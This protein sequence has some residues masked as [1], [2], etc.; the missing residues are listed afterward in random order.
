[1]QRSHRLSP[2]PR[3]KGS[4]CRRGMHELLGLVYLSTRGADVQGEAGLCTQPYFPFQ[5][6]CCFFSWVFLVRRFCKFN[7]RFKNSSSLFLYAYHYI[8]S[9]F[10]IILR[11]VASLSWLCGCACV[12]TSNAS[13]LGWCL[14]R[15]MLRPYSVSVP[16]PRWVTQ[17]WAGLPCPY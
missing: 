9:M 12:C 17:C 3:G 8:L 7:Y 16:R 11:P 1:M 4:D 13:L 6:R 2:Q 15:G 10:C 14:L 5:S